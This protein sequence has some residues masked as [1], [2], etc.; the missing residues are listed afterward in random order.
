[1]VAPS[2]SIRPCSFA[3]LETLW[4]IKQPEFFYEHLASSHIFV[5]I[6]IYFLYLYIEYKHAPTNHTKP[7]FENT[8][9]GSVSAASR[10]SVVGSHQLAS[11]CRA[12][13]AHAG[14]DLR[15]AQAPRILGLFYV[16]FSLLDRLGEP[17]PQRNTPE[18]KQK[19]NKTTRETSRAV[20]LWRELLM[21]RCS[22]WQCAHDSGDRQGA[23]R[24]ATGGETTCIELQSS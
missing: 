15:A 5:C 8:A 21:L 6:Y 9:A 23:L 2:S 16:G 4:L 17:V 3:V 12:E 24:G 20:L 14:R 22:S 18:E 10:S 1:M 7:T 13:L 19:I 11:A